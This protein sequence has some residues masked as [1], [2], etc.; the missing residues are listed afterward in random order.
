MATEVLSKTEERKTKVSRR[1]PLWCLAFLL[2]AALL[3]HL[4]GNILLLGA[5][6][7]R[8]MENRRK[9]RTIVQRNKT[10]H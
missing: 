9:R 5:V 2:T 3:L 4:C 6:V 7:G 8:V 10:K 1:E